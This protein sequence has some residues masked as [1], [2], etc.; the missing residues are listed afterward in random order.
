MIRRLRTLLILMAILCAPVQAELKLGQ[1]ATV[2]FATVEQG[3]KILASSD[4]F[5]Q[6]MSPFDR[7]ARVQSDRDTNESTYL[8]H[9]GAQVLAWN[10]DETKKIESAGP[11]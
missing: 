5:V 7:A 6:R 9:V 10:S 4:N 8:K 2:V 1:D 11:R 3:T